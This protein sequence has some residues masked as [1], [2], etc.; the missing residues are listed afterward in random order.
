MTGQ[1]YAERH[2]LTQ[3]GLSLYYRDYDSG[4]GD[5]AP[6]LC[7]A[8]L[9]RN[10][11][12]FAALAEAHSGERRIV[13]PDYRGR[14][15]SDRSSDWRSYT[16]ETYVNDIRHLIVAAGLHNF[17]LVGT[18]LG[19]FLSMGLGAAVP[20]AIAGVV[21]NDVGPQIETPATAEIVDY[22]GT[23]RPVPDWPAAV[24]AVR[25]RFPEFEAWD[26]ATFEAAARANYREGSDGRLHY[27]W[28]VDLVKPIRH[29]AEPRFDA[30]AMFRSLH[31]VP[32]LAI[33]GGNS[34]LLTEAGLNAMLDDRPDIAGVTVP[35]VGHA[36]RLHEP[37][38]SEAVAVFLESVDRQ[39]HDR[40][41]HDRHS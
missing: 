34:D 17:V 38:A 20:S 7:L 32:V 14:G 6:L 37:A 24:A 10:S 4:T 35:G 2:F 8:G 11:A 3:D 22:A 19:G 13:C 30:W 40:Q 5:G 12:D 41:Q 33:R 15:K 23:D 31:H 39:Q 16:P 9:T 26:D 21:L 36:P 25:E 18:S 27:D 29:G 1:T 28:D